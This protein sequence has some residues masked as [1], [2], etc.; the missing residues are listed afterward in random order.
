[1]RRQAYKLVVPRFERGGLRE[2]IAR[3]NSGRL[4]NRLSWK[5]NA[6]LNWL[7][8]DIRLFYYHA[9]PVW[10]V[11]GLRATFG[12]VN[13]PVD[14]VY[15]FFG[16]FIPRI[17]VCLDFVPLA[18][19]IWQFFLFIFTDAWSIIELSI[20][21][22][23]WDHSLNISH[24]EA[25]IHLPLKLWN[26]DRF[27]L[28]FW[29]NM[30][31]E[32]CHSGC[33]LWCGHLGRKW[34]LIRFHLNFLWLC[35]YGQAWLLEHIF[36]WRIWHTERFFSLLISTLWDGFPRAHLRSFWPGRRLFL[37]VKWNMRRVKFLPNAWI[38]IFIDLKSLLCH[39]HAA[40]VRTF[41]SS[42]LNHFCGAQ[43][44]LNT[45]SLC[46]NLG[47]KRS[48]LIVVENWQFLLANYKFHFLLWIA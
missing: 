15:V 16:T 38:S 6:R 31:I 1:M 19:R 21:L 13:R 12:N 14:S 44:I 34:W 40:G 9:V 23:S 18:G 24:S 41:A 28:I 48:V 45:L 47:R 26:N 8:A 36:P 39:S 27:R 4:P 35:F 3:Q 10:I 46:F 25:T 22:V 2:L 37:I 33:R 11:F 42:I 29:G 32:S 43:V 7:A 30:T 20:G 17:D 5:Q